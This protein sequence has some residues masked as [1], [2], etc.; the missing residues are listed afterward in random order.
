M[1]CEKYFKRNTVQSDY[2]HKNIEKFV[3]L[4][5][6]D[7]HNFLEGGKNKIRKQEPK[8]LAVESD[9]RGLEDLPQACFARVLEKISSVGEEIVNS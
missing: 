6:N 1:Q 2:D 7:V 5:Y 9:N 8:V 3:S 4:T